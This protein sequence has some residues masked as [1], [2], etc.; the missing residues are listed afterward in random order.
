MALDGYSGFVH[1]ESD[2]LTEAHRRSGIHVVVRGARTL[3]NVRSVPYAE[4]YRYLSGIYETPIEHLQRAAE[5][6]AVREAADE[7]Q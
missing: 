1:P 4:R 2:S 5:D 3:S 7:T 6:E